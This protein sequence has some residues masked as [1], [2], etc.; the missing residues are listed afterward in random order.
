M[1]DGDGEPR[2]MY[3]GTSKEFSELKPSTYGAAG[4][5][6]YLSTTK[7]KAESF[8]DREGGRVLKVYANLKKPLRVPFND[9]ANA[10]QWAERARAEGYDGLLIPGQGEV[11][12]FDPSQVR[13]WK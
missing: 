4:P 11:L 3:H 2:E 5:G 13:I 9:T 8:A 6:I 10:K 12:V 1:V 7:G